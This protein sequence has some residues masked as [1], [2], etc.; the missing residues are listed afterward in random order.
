[1]TFGKKSNDTTSRRGATRRDF[2]ASGLILA[3]A[4]LFPLNAYAQLSKVYSAER[5]L[6]FYNI[7]TDEKVKAVYW[8]RGAYVPQALD[9]INYIMRD[10]RTGEIKQIDKDLL[11]LLFS[12]HRELEG[13]G[14]YHVISGYRSEETNLL[15]RA[16]GTGVAKHSLHIEGMAI[17]IRLP[18]YELKTLRRAAVDLQM[19]GVGYYPSSDFVH[20]DTGRIRYW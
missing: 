2:L 4:T 17:D 12:L 6:H 9:E 19:G 16:T 15:L 1:M 14:P 18:G 10:Y 8:S 3:A 13:A 5:A 11:D 7:H 20:V